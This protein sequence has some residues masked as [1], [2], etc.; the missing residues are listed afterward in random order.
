MTSASGSSDCSAPA[1]PTVISAPEWDDADTR[2][3]LRIRLEAQGY[4]TAS[5]ADAVGAIRV[6]RE[7]RPDAILLDMG[8]PGGDGVVVM[9]RLKSFPALEHIPVIVVSAREPTTTGARAAEAG[10]H[11]YVQKPIDNEALVSAVRGALGEAAG[12]S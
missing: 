3:L 11:A 8:L 2:Q 10:A 1:S 4:E 9:E 12:S 5:A 6:A 7:E